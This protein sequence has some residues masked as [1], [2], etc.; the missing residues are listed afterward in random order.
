MDHWCHELKS[1]RPLD[2]HIHT[3]QSLWA[4]CPDIPIIRKAKV[5]EPYETFHTGHLLHLVL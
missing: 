2:I 1:K 5:P 3:R 4:Y